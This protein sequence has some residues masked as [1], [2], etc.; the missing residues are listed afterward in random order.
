VDR[1]LGDLPGYPKPLPSPDPA[2]CWKACNDTQ[3]CVAWSYGVPNCGLL[4]SS[5]PLCW[6]KSV[7]PLVVSDE[8]RVSG[9]QGHPGGAVATR[10]LINGQFTY[11]AG[12]L[13]QSFW[14]DG[15]YRAPTDEALAFDVK[16]W[17]ALRWVGLGWVGP[18]VAVS[19]VDL[20]V[21]VYLCLCACVLVCLF[22]WLVCW[23]LAC[24][25]GWLVGL[26]LGTSGSDD[27]RLELHPAAPKDQPAPVVHLRRA[28]GHC[29]PAGHDPEVR[30]CNARDRRALH[31]GAHGDGHWSTVSL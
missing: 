27:V 28:R 21:V 29:H 15:L 4:P 26:G 14:P 1:P 5:Q 6:L 9:A 10:P 19:A 20:R 3:A 30:R 25:V 22:G 7:R 31:Q 8:C 16:V 23:L 12:W 18:T 11:L 24:L 17:L 13:D 2:L